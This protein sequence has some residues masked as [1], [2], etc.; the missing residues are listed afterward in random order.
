MDEHGAPHPKAKHL[1]SAVPKDAKQDRIVVQIPIAYPAGKRA[2]AYPEHVSGAK[3]PGQHEKMHG[4]DAQKGAYA[5]AAAAGMS[6]AV[7]YMAAKAGKFEE[8][9][10]EELKAAAEATGKF[11]D[12]DFEPATAK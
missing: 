7:A 11:A 1:V 2:Y 5:A 12:A 4:N 6:L 8:G 9:D 3:K 10:E